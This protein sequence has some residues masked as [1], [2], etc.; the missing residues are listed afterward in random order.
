MASC[1]QELGDLFNDPNIKM[2][3]LDGFTII[4]SCD[5]AKNVK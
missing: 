2:K 4:D 5:G 3:S 1:P